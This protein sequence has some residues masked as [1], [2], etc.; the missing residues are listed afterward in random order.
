MGNPYHRLKTNGGR[1][2]P[3]KKANNVAK[4]ENNVAE[5]ATDK[6]VPVW[7]DGPNGEKKQ[8]LTAEVKALLEDSGWEAAE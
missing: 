1:N 5:A 6:F 8:A 3:T 7:M 2:P 4:K